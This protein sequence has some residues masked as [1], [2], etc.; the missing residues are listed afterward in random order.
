MRMEGQGRATPTSREDVCER[1]LETDEG[2]D[3]EPMKVGANK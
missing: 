1:S 3:W 2:E